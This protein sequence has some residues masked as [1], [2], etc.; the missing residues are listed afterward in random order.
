[1]LTDEIVQMVVLA[2]DPINVLSVEKKGR[3]FDVFPIVVESVENEL[4]EIFDKIPIDA[5]RLLAT[6]LVATCKIL[7]FEPIVVERVDV[8]D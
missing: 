3:K 4:S 2:F 8:P 7:K 6:V 5:L 1:M